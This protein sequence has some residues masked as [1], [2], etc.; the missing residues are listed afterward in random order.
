MIIT[1]RGLIMCIELNIRRVCRMYKLIQK[2]FTK[3]KTEIPLL[4]VTFNYKKYK[5]NGKKDSCDAKIHPNLANDKYVHNEINKLI[6]YI[7]GNYDMEE[8]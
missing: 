4:W 6:D 7:R 2:L 3:N 8:M 1:M 5:Q